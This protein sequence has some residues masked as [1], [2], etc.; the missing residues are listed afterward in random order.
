MFKNVK[1]KHSNCYQIGQAAWM[2][3][4]AIWSWVQLAPPDY[5]GWLGTVVSPGI[6]EEST[7]AISKLI[8]RFEK[9]VNS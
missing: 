3:D 8:L 1:V 7:V 9:Y 6:F 4:G 2:P 5:L